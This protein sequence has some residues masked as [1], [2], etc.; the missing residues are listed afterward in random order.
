MLNRL[1]RCWAG[2]SIVGVLLFGLWFQ[3]HA[4][5]ESGR[6]ALVVGNAAY[7]DMPL[8]NPG[9]DAKAMAGLLRRA[10]FQVDLQLDTSKVALVDAIHRFGRDISDPSVAFAVF[11]YAGHGFQQDWRNYL[12][13][14]DAK[15]KDSA[16]VRRETVEVGELIQQ[17]KQVSQSKGRS[18]LVILDACRD[19]PFAGSYRPAAK[20]LI[21]FDA[22]VGSVLAY[23]TAPGR[24]ALDGD[25]G[26]NGLYTKHLLREL[27]VKDV[28]IEDA[29]K[30]VRLNV[31]VESRG[32]QVPWEMASLENKVFLFPQTQHELSESELQRRFDEELAA[33]NRTREHNDVPALVQFIRAFPSGNTSE[34]A[35]ARL[36][37]LLADEIRKAALASASPGDDREAQALADRLRA[38]AGA[39]QA[40]RPAGASPAVSTAVASVP[41]AA[42]TTT[43][44][45]VATSTS[46]PATPEGPPATSPAASSPGAGGTVVA[47]ASPAAALGL[48]PVNLPATPYFSGQAEHRR[49]YRVGQQLDFRIIDNFTKAERPLSLKI[50]GLDVNADR[51]EFN[52]GELLSDLMGNTLANQRGS[53]STPRQFYPAEYVLGKRWHTEFKQ[54]R[55]SGMIYTFRYEVRVAGKEQVTVPAGTFDAWRI[56]AEGF[57]VGLSAYIKRTLW[58]VPGLPG[59]VAAETFVRLRNGNIE[60]NDRQELVAVRNP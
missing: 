22:P 44:P 29:F 45:A 30:R 48:P 42:P 3:A 21:P 4:A 10:G 46:V 9:N 1:I 12:V 38:E 14:V 47:L 11:Y 55:R 54:A 43:A 32:R 36:N 59:D 26:G 39:A 15:V 40:P 58:V 7:A 60:Q 25:S 50:T 52:G 13:P 35:Q 57:N 6:R 34:L 17:M 8:L 23:A 5:T 18:F 2:R 33:W 16:D 24:V 56:E 37:R 20:G 51:V 41:A 27:A 31:R 28:S 53:L 19:D 49:D